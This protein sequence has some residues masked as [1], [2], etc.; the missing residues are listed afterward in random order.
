MT[1][2]QTWTR[3]AGGRRGKH[4]QAKSDIVSYAKCERTSCACVGIVEEAQQDESAMDGGTTIE[5]VKKPLVSA[6]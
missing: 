3:R 1:G 2:G 5:G 4:R 6:G